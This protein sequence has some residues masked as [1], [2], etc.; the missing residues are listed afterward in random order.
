[1]NDKDGV[2]TVKNVLVLTIVIPI[3]FLLSIIS[4]SFA[5]IL[6][7]QDVDEVIIETGSIEINYSDTE[8]INTTLSPTREPESVNDITH[9]YK[10][11]F[12][13]DNVGT[14]NVILETYIDIITNNYK[15]DLVHYKLYDENNNIIKTG[16]IN[17]GKVSFFND[18]KLETKKNVSY[19]LLIWLDENADDSQQNKILKGTITAYAIQENQ[20]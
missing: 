3:I 18:I 13:I 10:N 5:W 6:A 4:A 7:T 15:T 11:T 19:S 12:R 8:I 9:A 17:N 2:K 1:M 14:G 20:K 16:N